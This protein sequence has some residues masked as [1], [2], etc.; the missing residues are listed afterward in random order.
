MKRTI[1]PEIDRVVKQLTLSLYGEDGNVIFVNW[2]EYEIASGVGTY[3]MLPKDSMRTREIRQAPR[4]SGVGSGKPTK[5]GWPDGLSEVGLAD[6]TR[7]QGEPVTGGSGQ[8]DLSSS[9]ET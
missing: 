7:R 9:K 5:R 6:S 1:S 3:G 2:R 8:Q 4:R